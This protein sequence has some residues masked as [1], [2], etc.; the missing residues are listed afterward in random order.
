MTVELRTVA[1]TPLRHTFTQVAEQIG[2]DKPASRYQEAVLGA[3]QDANF[4][5]RPTWDPG[6]ELFDTGRTAIRM[7]NWYA[8]KDPRQLYYGTWTMMRAKQQDAMESNFDFVESRGLVGR[9][10]AGVA[11]RALEVLLPLRHVAWGANMNNSAM[12]A[13][14]YGTAITSACMFHAMD[15]LGIAQYLT[16]FGL[17]LADQARIEQ[18]RQAWLDDP[19]WQPLRRYV[20]DS[21]VVQDWFELFVAQNL[22]LDGLLYPLVYGVVV[23]DVLAAG[24]GT[25]VA[26]LTAFM[27]EWHAESAKWVDAQVKTAAAESDENRRLL[28][29][30]VRQ[31]RGR[32]VE[33]LAPVASLALGAQADGHLAGVV[34]QFDARCKKLGLVA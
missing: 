31:W 33:A 30:W 6:H 17:A 2:A 23:D 28:S 1:I 15:H 7:K 13:Y 26:M 25:A 9:L 19:R 27:T 34:E 11:E 32:A 21:F 8:F 18:A 24:G 29:G 16:R 4:Q 12:C 22:A 14:G 10:P 20:E 5:Y 3:Q